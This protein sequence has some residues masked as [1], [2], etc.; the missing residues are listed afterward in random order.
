[1]AGLFATPEE[2]AQEQRAQ[3]E[4]RALQYARLGPE[5][6]G[7][8][9]GMRAGQSF[10]G[11]LS[12]PNPAMQRAQAVQDAVKEVNLGAEPVGS[13]QYFDNLTKMLQKRG[14]G[15]EA[16][17]V[18]D[19]ATKQGLAGAQTKKA[20]ADAREAQ[21]KASREELVTGMFAPGGGAG[22][23]GQ[24]EPALPAEVGGG[25]PAP[26]KQGPEALANRSP[27][28]WE[29]LSFL[30]N[31]PEYASHAQRLRTAQEK[32]ATLKLAQDP[33]SGLFTDLFDSKHVGTAA[34]NAQ[35]LLTEGRMEMSRAQELYKTLATKDLSLSTAQAARDTQQSEGMLSPDALRVSAAKYI[36]FG[37]EPKGM[38][39][40]SAI[41]K[42]QI[43]DLAAQMGK[44]LGLTEWEQAMLPQDNRVKMKAVDS[45]TKWGATVART[46]DKLDRDLQTAL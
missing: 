26:T 25:P 29:S 7:G 5:N 32:A 9:L 18:A 23:Q 10:G 22:A 27:E 37:E 24:A 28:W 16:L 39:N 36:L 33:E 11:L 45:L 21:A 12:G 40:M 41:Q 43:K 3:E 17:Q 8:Y 34:K 14:F 19:Y 42:K 44:G 1:M 35:R 20:L 46:A 6:A 4:A 31:R 13:P 2:I 15:G 30:A 38:G